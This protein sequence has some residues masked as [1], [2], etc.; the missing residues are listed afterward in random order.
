M[1]TLKILSGATAGREFSASRFP[2]SI[3]RESD[4]DLSSQEA[5]VWDHHL[6]IELKP[7]ASFQVLCNA[8]TTVLVNGQATRDSVLRNGD[9]LTLGSLEI[10]CWLSPARPKSLIVAEF[11]TW[12]LVAAVVLSE[13][14][15]LFRVLP[16]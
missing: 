15:L 8:S 6:V 11:L 7:D 3:G 16:H 13:S 14:L 4:A 5:G 2:F 10:D 9:H 12:L 1:L